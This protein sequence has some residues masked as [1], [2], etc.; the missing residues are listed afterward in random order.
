M[1]EIVRTL[2]ELLLQLRAKSLNGKQHD[3]KMNGA[4][5]LLFEYE[6]SGKKTALRM[7]IHEFSEEMFGKIL[8]PR[9]FGAMLK[10]VESTGIKYHVFRNATEFWK[11][12]KKKV[13]VEWKR[14]N[15]IHHH[16]VTLMFSICMITFYLS[17]VYGTFF[18][19]F[20]EK[21]HTMATAGLCAIALLYLIQNSKEIIAGRVLHRKLVLQKQ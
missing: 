3:E 14:I 19:S 2:T 8:S 1:K 7:L 20:K 11:M 9:Q 6:N 17:C 12:E 15:T 4:L 13:V 21:M 16:L 10:F 18:G 5:K